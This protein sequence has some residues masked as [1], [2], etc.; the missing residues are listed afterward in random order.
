MGECK[1]QATLKALLH[2]ALG[3][4]FGNLNIP[5]RMKKRN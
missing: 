3:L 5:K 2:Y 1:V 4:R